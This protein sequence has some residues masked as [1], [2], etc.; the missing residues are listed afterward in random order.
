MDY[1]EIAEALGKTPK[2]VDNTMT[3]IKNKAKTILEEVGNKN[4]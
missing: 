3:R 2:S 4:G 1:K